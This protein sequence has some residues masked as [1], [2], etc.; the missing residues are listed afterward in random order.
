MPNEKFSPGTISAFSFPEQQAY[1]VT[2][3]AP[4]VPAVPTDPVSPFEKYL[5]ALEN[6]QPAVD[7]FPGS[8][9]EPSAPAF[10]P[11]SAPAAVQSFTPTA[12][13]A[14]VPASA[15]AQSG[16]GQS[17]ANLS[18]PQTLNQEQ[19]N[20]SAEQLSTSATTIMD[21]NTGLFIEAIPNPDFVEPRVYPNPPRIGRPEIPP[22]MLDPVMDYDL[23][24]WVDRYIR[25]PDK[26]STTNPPKEDENVKYLTEQEVKDSIGDQTPTPGVPPGPD[27]GKL[28]PERIPTSGSS[29]VVRPRPS[30]LTPN[31]SLTEPQKY[32]GIVRKPG[33]VIPFNMP[34]E[35]PVPGRRSAELLAP[36]YFQDINYDPDEILAAAMRVIRGR[37]AGRSLMD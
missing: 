14:A 34:T 24:R 15:S 10:T 25:K 2:P 13:T 3:A 4:A 33:S 5:M 17:A 26:P 31:M 22:G 35:V 21:P 29:S 23:W 36:G 11:M 32:T 9:Q 30:V 20:P 12:S 6:L 28:P 27:I 37:G 18:L 1:P 19:L 8:Y 7:M 16:S